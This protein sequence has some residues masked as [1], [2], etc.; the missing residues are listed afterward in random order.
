MFVRE[1]IDATKNRE[2]RIDFVFGRKIYESIIFDIE[3]RRAK[4]QFFTRIDELCFNFLN[5]RYDAET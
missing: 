5:Q 2:M 3:I 4:T 1:V